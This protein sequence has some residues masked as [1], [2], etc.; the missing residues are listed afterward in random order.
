MYWCT[1]GCEQ[2]GFSMKTNLTR[3]IRAYVYPYNNT[4]LVAMLIL[5]HSEH[6]GQSV[7]ECPCCP[8]NNRRMFG[9][10]DNFIA[11][12]ELHNNGKSRRVPHHPDAA[13]ILEEERQK[14]RRPGRPSKQH[15]Q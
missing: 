8:E 9:R 5:I 7:I 14:N 10:R 12:L 4:P 15:P 11:H 2:K 13:S 6:G 3:H 1:M